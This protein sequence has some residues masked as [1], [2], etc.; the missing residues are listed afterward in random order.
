LS[1]TAGGTVLAAN[2]KFFSV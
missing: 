1:P 2:T